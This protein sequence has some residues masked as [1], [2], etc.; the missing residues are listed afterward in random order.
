MQ[1]PGKSFYCLLY[2]FLSL[3][4]FYSVHAAKEGMA[5]PEAKS[6]TPNALANRLKKSLFC[7][8]P[9]VTGLK[10]LTKDFKKAVAE[11]D[12]MMGSLCEV[13]LPLLAQ[14]YSA[15]FNVWVGVHASLAFTKQAYGISNSFS[16][17]T[18]DACQTLGGVERL[19]SKK[20]L[21]FIVE[22]DE[23]IRDGTTIGGQSTKL[24]LI[25][26][27]M[28]AQH[29]LQRN[30]NF[31]NF[32]NSL[33]QVERVLFAEPTVPSND[34]DLISLRCKSLAPV[35]QDIAIL[36][37]RV[38]PVFSTEA[39]FYSLRIELS[40]KKSCENFD[41]EDITRLMEL[42]NNTDRF[43]QRGL[44]LASL[45]MDGLDKKKIDWAITRTQEIKDMISDLKKGNELG[46]ELEPVAIHFL[47]TTFVNTGLLTLHYLKAICQL[48]ET[49]LKKLA[50]K[51][52]DSCIDEALRI[53]E[54][55]RN[56]LTPVLSHMSKT[57]SSI[58]EPSKKK[59]KKKKKELEEILQ[60]SGK[61]IN[62]FEDLGTRLFWNLGEQRSDNNGKDKILAGLH[63]SLGPLIGLIKQRQ[64]LNPIEDVA[65]RPEER[66]KSKK[67][68]STAENSFSKLVRALTGASSAPW[69]ENR[70][71]VATLPVYHGLASKRQYLL[72]L[73]PPTQELTN[74]GKEEY[75]SLTQA[76][77]LVPKTLKLRRKSDH[78]VAMALD[79]LV[80]AGE[81]LKN[82]GKVPGELV[83]VKNLPP[84]LRELFELQDET[85]ADHLLFLCPG[86]I[87][88]HPDQR[89]DHA[90][91]CWKELTRGKTGLSRVE[92]L[93]FLALHVP[94]MGAEAGLFYTRFAP[95]PKPA[96]Q[97][98]GFAPYNSCLV[99]L[100]SKAYQQ[101]LSADFPNKLQ[102]YSKDILTRY[103]E[104]LSKLSDEEVGKLGKY[105]D[106]IFRF[107][108]L[109]AAYTSFVGNTAT[110]KDEKNF[111]Y[112]YFAVLD[113]LARELE[114]K[115]ADMPEALGFFIDAFDKDQENFL[116]FSTGD[117]GPVDFSA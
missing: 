24:S 71:M 31:L 85:F 56:G 101:P 77:K 22:L 68:G 39:F 52:K 92:A 97:D 27:S 12:A 109:F 15:L 48:L 63:S 23:Y 79:L 96:L 111:A 58:E 74:S 98:A 107:Q 29:A 88:A 82:H 89:Y 55:C 30:R 34:A 60:V 46:T 28:F 8:K 51:Y 2:S 42:G 11:I 61:E 81:Y 53:L 17:L 66:K 40:K 105:I 35:W 100:S 25:D 62:G 106:A 18:K 13:D 65:R 86:F 38:G 115:R 108:L 117:L 44:E 4:M 26:L 3:G 116:G 84:Y 14:Y 103:T 72:A 41:E 20:G 90:M 50:K 95:T 1:K 6:I 43:L 59:G 113:T 64:A 114:K 75:D 7:T 73:F 83:F 5:S 47:T 33:F 16:L 57:A 112:P 78:H 94:P 99:P 37:G 67:A 19:L 69:F 36:G 54:G 93:A 32:F 87:V 70:D 21:Q 102:L 110:Y 10:T 104:N 76:E 9:N 45:K 49:R 91:A 80:F